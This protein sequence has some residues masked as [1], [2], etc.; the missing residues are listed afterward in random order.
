MYIWPSATIHTLNHLWSHSFIGFIVVHA[1]TNSAH[2]QIVQSGVRYQEHISCRSDIA[3]A[4]HTLARRR[5]DMCIFRVIVDT[6][7]AIAVLKKMEQNGGQC[8]YL[9]LAATSS[10]T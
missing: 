7:H 4:I 6:V 8:G 3:W 9:T 10:Y 1:G 5:S 2:M